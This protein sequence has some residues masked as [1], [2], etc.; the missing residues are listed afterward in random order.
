MRSKSR[1]LLMQKLLLHAALTPLAITGHG[2]ARYRVSRC[3][4]CRRHHLQNL[5]RVMRSGL[6]RF[7]LFV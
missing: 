4:V 7:D 6:F 1:T 5:R 2:A 3:P